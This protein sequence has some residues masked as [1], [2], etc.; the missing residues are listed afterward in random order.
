MPTNKHAFIRY[1]ALNKCFRNIGKRYF[2]ENLVEACNE[3][4]YNYTGEQ[5]GV[6]KRQVYSDIK[7]MESHSGFSITLVR[8]KE[9]HKT[10]YSYADPSQS[11]NSHPISETE[12]NQLKEALITLDRFKGLPQFMWIEEMKARL[13]SEFEL[14][15]NQKEV[16]QF[17]QN[18]YLQGL[19]FITPIYNALVYEKLLKVE[20]K[21]FKQNN[22]E[23]KIV[24]PQLL[25]QFNNRWFLFAL[26]ENS[27]ILTNFALDRIITIDETSGNYVN[28]E[29]QFMEYFESNS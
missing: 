4:I 26:I 5:Y 24:S 27:D 6:K 12:A 17:D 15:S 14:N 28:S 29:I 23:I 7:F 11:I 10:Y 22:S 19:E 25:K 3:A 8:K 2:I 13:N 18:E 1:Q 9:S 16:I 20:Y 21:G